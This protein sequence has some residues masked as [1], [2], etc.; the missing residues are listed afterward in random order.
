MDNKEKLETLEEILDV[1]EGS[2]SPDTVLADLDE[3][4][5]ITRLSL[6]IYFDEELGKKISGDEIK[7]FEKVEDIMGLMD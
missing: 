4:D 6:L 7:A 5:S 1:E 3:W 2:L